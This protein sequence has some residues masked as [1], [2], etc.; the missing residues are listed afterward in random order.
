MTEQTKIGR[1][2]IAKVTINQDFCSR[3]YGDGICKANLT[4]IIANSSD[5]GDASAWD[6]TASF[7]ITTVGT[8]SISGVDAVVNQIEKSTDTEYVLSNSSNDLFL[9]KTTYYTIYIDVISGMNEFYFQV[10]KTTGRCALKLEMSTGTVTNG[11]GWDAFD[12]VEVTELAD[13][14]NYKITVGINAE[15]EPRSKVLFFFLNSGA[16]PS[17]GAQAQ[18]YGLMAAYDKDQQHIDTSGFAIVGEETEKCFNTRKTC[19]DPS[20]YDIETLP[21]K[22]IKSRSPAPDDDYYLPCL[23]S[24]SI[25]PASLNPGGANKSA[26]PFG[27]RATISATFKDF[28]HNDKRVDPYVDDRDYDPLERGTFWTKWAARNPYYLHRIMTHESGYL[29][30]GQIVDSTVRTFVITS[31]DGVDSNGNV[32]V[33]GKDILTLA[34]NSKAQAPRASSGILN[35]DIN[36]SVTTLTAGPSG[37]GD[38]EYPASGYIRIEKEILSFTRSGDVF[39]VVRGQRATTAE[40]HSKDATIQLCLEYDSGLAAD[41]LEDLFTQYAGIDLAF[42]DTANWSV[43]GSSYL[44]RLYSTL[45]TEPTGVSD[46]VGEMCEQMFFSV[47]WDERT[48]LV[49]LRAVRAPQDDVIYDLDDYGNIIKDSVAWKDLPDQLV[50]EVN[51][52]YGQINPTEKLDETSNYTTVETYLNTSSSSIKKHGVNKI[53][54]IH[55]RWIPAT[56]TATANDL[57]LKIANRFGEIPKQITF[58][59]DAK[60]SYLWLGDFV[61]LQNRLLVDFYGSVRQANMQIFSASEIELGTKFSYTANEFFLAEPEDPDALEV[62]IGSN[63]LNVNLRDL[64][65]DQF[66]ITLDG[67][68]TINF[69]VRSGVVIGGDTCG[70]GVNVPEAARD[71]SNDF[72]EGGKYLTNTQNLSLSTAEIGL[73]PALQRAYITEVKT[74]LVDQEYHLY[75]N[76]GAAGAK[77][78]IKIVEYPKSVALSTGSFPSGTTINL[79]IESGAKILGEGGNGQ[80]QDLVST[81]GPYYLKGGDGGDALSVEHP[82]TIYNDGVIAG[83][84]GGGA[85]RS[86][87]A[88]STKYTAVTGGGGAG[89]LQSRVRSDIQIGTTSTHTDA[90]PG[91]QVNG[92]VGGTYENFV[93]NQYIRINYVGI[94]KSA[95]G[96]LGQRGQRRTESSS[97]DSNTVEYGV[98]GGPG[99]AIRA[100][101]NLITWALKGDVIGDEVV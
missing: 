76:T 23:T 83:G 82:I 3:S 36:N 4:N 43:E 22:F 95:G 89:S 52:Y 24:V 41:I 97:N 64:F 10:Y 16:V 101:K 79:I 7:N 96:D 26:S 58:K 54:T 77:A 13:N 70:G 62:I 91:D 1:Q 29:L 80:A 71:P 56:A 5:L 75:Q 57:A 17:L 65:D 47:W 74:T 6:Y 20:N 93:V 85:G 12:F 30:N 28:P 44:P 84:G 73:I 67:S 14:T 32:K 37:V 99:D 9:N 15:N 34:E 72:Y 60:D 48:N 66:G 90:S 100:G 87:L 39:T 18:I 11:F 38:L 59:V 61:R 50:T 25:G 49:K 46:L 33:S 27:T 31:F 94:E 40:E 19:Q 21:L 78:R 68:E 81:F 69:R 88:T 92:G 55:S 45:I 42:L 51:V 63:L 2:P 8:R 98:G 53:K 35:A 86:L